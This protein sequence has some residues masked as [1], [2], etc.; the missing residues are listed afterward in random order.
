[1]R[2]PSLVV[3]ALLF[4]FAAMASAADAQEAF[5]AVGHVYEAHF[6]ADTVFKLDFTQAGQMTY[7]SLAGPTRGKVETVHYTAVPVQPPAFMVYWREAD[8]TRVVHVENFGRGHVW[9]NIALPGGEFVHL[10][11][12]LKQVR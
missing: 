12:E 3:S 2:V 10:D 4:G 1:M 8:G 6:S 5:P 11:G 7:T 9:T